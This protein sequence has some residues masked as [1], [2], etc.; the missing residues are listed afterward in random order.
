MANQ[1]DTGVTVHVDVDKLNVFRRELRL[2]QRMI[3]RRPAYNQPVQ[4]GEGVTLVSGGFA[5]Y[6]GTELAPQL[7][8]AFEDTVLQVDGVPPADAQHHRG[9]RIVVAAAPERVY[10]LG[11]W[12]L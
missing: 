4:Y 11:Y 9:V 1:P 12:S 3:A 10:D 2:G 8:P 6:G 5:D 7:A